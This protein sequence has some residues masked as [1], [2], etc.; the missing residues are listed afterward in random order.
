MG[1]VL[2]HAKKI[3]TLLRLLRKIPVWTP[4]TFSLLVFTH[5]AAA[6]PGMRHIGNAPRGLGSVAIED[7]VCG[8]KMKGKTGVRRKRIIKEHLAPAC[9]KKVVVPAHRPM[10][11]RGTEDVRM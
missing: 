8:H 1:N 2:L 5:L 11:A 3:A 6:W 7:R 10:P 9:H 4:Q